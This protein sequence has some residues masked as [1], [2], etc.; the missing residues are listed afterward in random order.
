MIAFPEPPG[1]GMSKEYIDSYNG[2]MAALEDFC[3]KHAPLSRFEYSMQK[4]YFA[5]KYPFMGEVE[6]IAVKRDVPWDIALE[7]YQFEN[8][9]EIDPVVK[10]KFLQDM[11][12]RRNYR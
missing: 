9:V 12:P 6:I 10:E 3:K 2:T 1:V 7:I 8:K 4:A 11:T 5:P